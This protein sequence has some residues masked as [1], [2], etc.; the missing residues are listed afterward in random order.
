[1]A[2][3]QNGPC[4]LVAAVLGGP[5][6]D[7]GALVFGD[8]IEAILTRFA[9]GQDIAGMKLAGGAAAVGFSALAAQQ[10]KGP[11]NHR[12]G[13]LEAAQG[14]GQGGVSAPELLAEL[15]EVG[16]QTVSLII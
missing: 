14:G 7:L 10:V 4:A 5:F 16:A 2:F 13:A 12:L 8:R 6:S 3:G 15:R 1:M 11:P 9:A